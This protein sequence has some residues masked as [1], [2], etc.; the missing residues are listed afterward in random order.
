MDSNKKKAVEVLNT[1][2]IEL[3][4]KVEQLKIRLDVLCKE[5]GGCTHIK[6]INKELTAK[7]ESNNGINLNA[8]REEE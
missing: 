1:A 3:V 8:L 5:T 2:L 7:K 4:E 6:Q